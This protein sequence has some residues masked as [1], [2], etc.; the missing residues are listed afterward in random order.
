MP[1]FILTWN[2]SSEAG[3][4]TD[5]EYD[6]AVEATHRG[7]TLDGRWSTGRRTSGISRGDDLYLLVQNAE[8]RGIIGH[9]LARDEIHTDQ[10]WQ[11]ETGIASYVAVE[12]H[13]LLPETDVLP[14]SRLKSEVP[15]KHRW[16]PRQ[17]GTM[18]TSEAEQLLAT[19]WRR[20][21]TELGV[22]APQRKSQS[23]TIPGGH[24]ER[25]VRARLGQ[26]AFRD[27]L[28]DKFGE[29]CAVTGPTPSGALEAAHLYPFAASSLHDPDGGL[30]L[31][32]DIHAL[33]DRGQI[34][35][36]PS[37]RISV[38]PTLRGFPAYSDLDGARVKVTLTTG[39]KDWLKKRAELFPA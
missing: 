31:R 26:G 20:H 9:G 21:L 13:R 38:H 8:H 5:S 15:M 6:D 4:W 29:Q 28:L 22:M 30:L 35:I 18:V 24:I 34:S 32:S 23:Q 33:F 7:V 3:G 12:W 27:V 10:H 11:S 36:S 39:H 14:L 25:T 37:G 19:V 2:F 17:S 1:S 16:E